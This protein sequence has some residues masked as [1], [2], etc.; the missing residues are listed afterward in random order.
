MK[1][2][3]KLKRKI[4]LQCKEEKSLDLFRCRVRQGKYICYESYCKACEKVNFKDWYHKNLKYNKYRDYVRNCKRF[5]LTAFEYEAIVLAQ[6]NKC[7]ICKL[8]EVST[9]SGV[10]KKLAIDHCHTTGKV[11]ALLCNACNTSI[12]LMKENVELLELAIKYLNKFKR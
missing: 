11:R 5:G 6:N 2:Y 8:P 3:A 10:I 4:C 1:M 9:R 7:A 12:G